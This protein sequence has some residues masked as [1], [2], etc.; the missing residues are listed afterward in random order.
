MF[1]SVL[2]CFSPADAAW[3]G[4]SLHYPES[5]PHISF[6]ASVFSRLGTKSQLGLRERQATGPSE[7][8]QPHTPSYEKG[9]SDP[10]LEPHTSPHAGAHQ[11]GS[12]NGDQASSASCPKC[13]RLKPTLELLTKQ[14]R[15]VWTAHPGKGSTP[16]PRSV[17]RISAPATCFTAFTPRTVLGTTRQAR[18]NNFL[19]PTPQRSKQATGFKF[20]GPGTRVPTCRAVIVCFC[21]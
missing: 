4:G 7:T 14:N 10:P 1:C 13:H 15:C 8:L 6:S 17:P 5:R 11:G 20:K 12:V 18:G 2:F 9:L 16:P 21:L 19:A 3:T